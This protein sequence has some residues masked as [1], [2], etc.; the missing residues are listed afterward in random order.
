MQLLQFNAVI[1]NFVT[2]DW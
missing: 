1:T 2:L